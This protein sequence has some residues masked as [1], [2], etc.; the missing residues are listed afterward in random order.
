MSQ[1][2]AATNFVGN[3]IVALAV[4][5]WEEERGSGEID[6]LAMSRPQTEGAI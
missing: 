4:A 5:R 2:R 6:V 1:C 3:G